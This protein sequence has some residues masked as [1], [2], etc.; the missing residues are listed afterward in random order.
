MA[1]TTA[2]AVKQ[3]LTTSLTDTVVEAYIDDASAMVDEVFEDD[4]D[5][6]STLLTAIEKWLTAHMI[7]STQERFGKEEGAG[8]AYIKYTGVYGEG[9]RS[10]PYGQMVMNLDTTGLMAATGGKG[11]TI[12]AIHSFED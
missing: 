3:I 5:I 8:G 9:L 2:T 4:T 11:A 10:T 7:A 1:R 6:G 12:K